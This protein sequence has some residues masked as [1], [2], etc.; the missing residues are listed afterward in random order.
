M[1]SDEEAVLAANSA[2]YRAFD[3]R[4]LDA[5]GRIWAR[6]SGVACVH[7]GWAALHGREL[8]L[9]SWK[10]I[11]ENP[12][13]PRIACLSAQAYV[14]GDTAFVICSERLAE[15]ELVATNIFVREDSVWKLA[16]HQASPAPPTPDPP[17]AGTVH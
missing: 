13:A 5:M 16:H 15:G 7:P 6:K 2:F 1:A 8:V 17:A 11:L 14:Q 4:D 3:T 10:N 9:G 12:S